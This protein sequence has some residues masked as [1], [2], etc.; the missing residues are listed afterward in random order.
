[1]QRRRDGKTG[2][3]GVKAMV[4]AAGRGERM[5]PLSDR[6]PKPLIEVGG[7]PLIE[8]CVER[9]VDAGIR[10]MVI[11]HAWLGSQIVEALG[12]G[13]RLGAAIRYSAE[14]EG[15]LDVG[16]AIVKALPLLGAHPFIAVNA[17]VWSEYPFGRLLGAPRKLAHLV[18]VDNTAYHP[19]G[20]FHLGEG[21]IEGGGRPRLTFSGIAAYR[22]E[23]FAGYPPGRQALR[24]ILETAI[25]RGEVSG[26][27]FRG[28]WFN[29]GTPAEL[30]ALGKALC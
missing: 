21:G 3:A 9:L 19:Q 12:D 17:D 2:G 25:E 18:L 16:G 15:A 11:N 24:P 22:V 26:E 1:M 28:R 30:A 5:R 13:T 6:R 14:P 23:L 7:R 27:H 4:L 10:E 29:V 8:H 20:D